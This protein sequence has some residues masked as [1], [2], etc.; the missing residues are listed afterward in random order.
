[1]KKKENIKNAKDRG[2]LSFPIIKKEEYL[3]MKKVILS[4]IGS[5]MKIWKNEEGW[6]ADMKKRH[7]E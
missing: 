4:L 1:M 5:L 7:R 3:N 2:S 6:Y